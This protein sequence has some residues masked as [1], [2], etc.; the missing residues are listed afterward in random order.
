MD[1]LPNWLVPAAAA[2]LVV[3]DMAVAVYIFSRP[4]ATDARWVGLL[5]L[6]GAI[7]CLLRILSSLPQTN[8]WVAATQLTLIVLDI[9]VGLAGLVFAALRWVAAKRAGRRTDNGFGKLHELVVGMV[10]WTTGLSLL[11]GLNT[12]MP[13][14]RTAMAL[15]ALP[16]L[17]LLAPFA[18][19]AVKSQR[20]LEA[21]LGLR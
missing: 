10:L 12:D 17:L 8:T 5:P 7:L 18:V 2:G 14:A 1:G 4:R 11:M 6:L 16:A 15:L 19:V 20:E 9:A 21:S 13:G 3:A